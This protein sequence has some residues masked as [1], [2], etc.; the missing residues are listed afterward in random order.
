MCNYIYS[1][2][3]IQRMLVCVLLRPQLG[4]SEFRVQPLYF[5]CYLVIKPK[6]YEKT[7]SLKVQLQGNTLLSQKAIYRLSTKCKQNGISL[8]PF[9]GK[10]NAV[11]NVGRLVCYMESKFKPCYFYLLKFNCT[12]V[13]SS[14]II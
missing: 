8:C 11:R 6:I 3:S 9:H 2:K 12:K 1:Y 10:T 4:F 7:G 5:Y 14:E 13:T